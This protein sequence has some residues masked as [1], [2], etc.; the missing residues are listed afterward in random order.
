MHGAGESSSLK[1]GMID[2]I[3]GTLGGV[4]LVYVSQPMDTVKVKMQTFPG[5]YKG[6]VNC[7]LQTFRR[8]GIVRGLYAGTLPAVV[9]NVA[10]N[11]VLFAAYGACQQAVGRLV[12]KPAVA[13]LSALENATAGFLAAFFSSFT[14]CPTELIKCKLQALRETAGGGK[15]RPTISSY[16]LVS[17]I[18][19]TEGV[20]GMFRG[21]TSTFA[22]EMPGYFF[23][24][25]GYEQTRAL[26]ARP[27]QSKDEIGPVRTMVAGAVGGV[28]LWTVIFPADVIKSRIQVYS[29][30][31]S[32]TQVGLDIFRKE[33]ALAFY[34]GL[35][36]TIVRTIPATAVLF[37]VYEYTKKTLTKLLE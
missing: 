4:A 27:G 31:A 3:A 2:F 32:M 1:T 26:L 33:G 10:E 12:H 20:P 8:D 30:R 18:L 35:L 29:M 34:N 17:Q 25:G 15:G 36:P 9:A 14:L 16:A 5:L 13:D 37:V 19:R 24:F 7:T 22:R 23:F 6:L 11:S 28:A 21:L